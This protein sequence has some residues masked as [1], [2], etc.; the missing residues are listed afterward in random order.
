MVQQLQLVKPESLC[1]KLCRMNPIEF[2]GSE[3]SLDAEKWLS[4]IQIIMELMELND[5]ERIMCTSYM[6]KRE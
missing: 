3:N 1:D 5:Q 6:L 4:Y 2:E